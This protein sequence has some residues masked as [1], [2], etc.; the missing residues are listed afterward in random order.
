VLTVLSSTGG[1]AV[2]QAARSLNA[3]S[4]DVSHLSLKDIFLESVTVED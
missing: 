2:V 3:R 1:D 4:I